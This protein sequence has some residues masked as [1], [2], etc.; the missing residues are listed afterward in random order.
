M[1]KNKA[2][3]INTP[4]ENI[5]VFIVFFIIV[6]LIIY[7]I[8]KLRNTISNKL[9]G[10]NIELFSN[11]DYEIYY[12]NLDRRKDRDKKCRNELSKSNL[13]KNY[14]RFSAVDGKDVQLDKY[15]HFNVDNMEKKRGWIGCAESHIALWEKC[16][17]LNKNILVFEDDVILKDDYNQNMNISLN[18]LPDNFDIIYYHTVTYAKYDSYN[19]Y[20]YKLKD[21]NYSTINYLLHPSGAKKLLEYIKPYNPSVQVDTYIVRMTKTN[22]L[23]AYLFTLPTIYTIQDYSESD[24]QSSSNRYVVHDFH[25][26]LLKNK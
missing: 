15:L 6:V 1:K 19:K 10:M 11:N 14:K 24:V 20:Y 22:K 8:Y 13:L 5:I 18:N 4:T 23:N 2:I 9:K 17:E 16:V 12:I 7:I 3:K 26:K 25:A 21:S